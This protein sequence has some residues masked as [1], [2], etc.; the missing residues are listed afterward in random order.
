METRI[1]LYARTEE[2]KTVV[3]IDVARALSDHTVVSSRENC[4]KNPINGGS[5]IHFFQWVTR[6]DVSTVTSKKEELPLNDLDILRKA[7]FPSTLF[8]RVASL[9]KMEVEASG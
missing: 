3:Y 2:H 6:A 5:C 7:T 4:E 1:E 8:I 9:C